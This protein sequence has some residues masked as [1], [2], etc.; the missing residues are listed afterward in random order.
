MEK[1]KRKRKSEEEDR[2]QREKSNGYTLRCYNGYFG[3]S[4]WLKKN[5]F[6]ERGLF[7]GSGKNPARYIL[8]LIYSFLNYFTQNTVKNIN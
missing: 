1:E 6:D 7:G 2:R 8:C 3:E 4:F 5:L